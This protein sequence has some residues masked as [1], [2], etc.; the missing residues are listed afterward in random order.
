M[1]YIYIYNHISIII[2]VNIIVI[3]NYFNCPKKSNIISLSLSTFGVKC[4]LT[5]NKVER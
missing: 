4:D 2:H 1:I 5:I 3:I